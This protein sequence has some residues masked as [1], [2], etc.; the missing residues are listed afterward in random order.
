MVRLRRLPGGLGIL[1]P[2]WPRPRRLRLLRELLGEP[3]FLRLRRLLRLL[4]GL[5]GRPRFLRLLRL[6]RQLLP[7]WLLRLRRLLGWLLGEPGFLRLR[8]LPLP[9][10]PPVLLSPRMPGIGVLVAHKASPSCSA[11]STARSRAS[12]KPTGSAP[13]VPA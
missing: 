2:G 12:S 7:R 6:P 1:L 11:N 4:G 5:L 3:G 9:L 10:V 8:L 13:E